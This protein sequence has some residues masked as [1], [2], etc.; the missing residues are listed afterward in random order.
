V[1]EEESEEFNVVL[2]PFDPEQ[3]LAMVITSWRNSAYYRSAGLEH[4]PQVIIGYS[5]FTNTHLDWIYV[6]DDYRRNGIGSI[7]CP[8]SIQTYPKEQTKIGFAI[9]NKKNPTPGESNEH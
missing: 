3:D 2:R 9:L 6:K 1:N 4:N 8:K 7:L 5:V